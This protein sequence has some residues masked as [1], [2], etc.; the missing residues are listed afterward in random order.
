[1]PIGGSHLGFQR[2]HF[3]KEIQGVETGTLSQRRQLLQM[4]TYE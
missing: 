2:G 4:G 1:M 3:Q